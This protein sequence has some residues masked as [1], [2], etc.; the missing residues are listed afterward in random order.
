MSWGRSSRDSSASLCYRLSKCGTLRYGGRRVRLRPQLAI[1]MRAILD[2]D[3][4][5]LAHEVIGEAL[6]R[7]RTFTY[8]QISN[9][10]NSLNNA[11]MPIGWPHT[12][13][14]RRGDILIQRQFS[15]KAGAF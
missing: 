1:V 15:R 11:I 6:D 4:D 7:N 3:G 5:R 13:S 9:I 10:V 14:T 12:Y 2:A 8:K